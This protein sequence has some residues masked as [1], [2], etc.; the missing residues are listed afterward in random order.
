[1]YRPKQSGSCRIPEDHDNAGGIAGAEFE[2][3]KEKS[4][5]GGGRKGDV[6]A[7]FAEEGGV[8]AD[9]VDRPIEPEVT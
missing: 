4:G 6:Y 2:R 7:L 8:P 3:D 9:R 1:M 5:G